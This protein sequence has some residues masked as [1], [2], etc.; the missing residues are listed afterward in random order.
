M[1]KARYDVLSILTP[2]ARHVP[3][4]RQYMCYKAHEML[5]KAHKH[6]K[7]NI[8]ERWHD[9]DKY[10]MSLSDIVWTEEQIIQ[11]VEIAL[12]DPFLR[13]YMVRKKSEREIMDN[14]L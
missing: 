8:M 13:G 9:D 6:K 5:K 14:F 1:N 7:W 11:Y 2:G 10:L 3:S 4:V 12:E